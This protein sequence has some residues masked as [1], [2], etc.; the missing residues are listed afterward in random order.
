M[1]N[2]FELANDGFVFGRALLRNFRGKFGAFF[3]VVRLREPRFSAADDFYFSLDVEKGNVARVARLLVFDFEAFFVAVFD[4][5]FDIAL[6]RRISDAT[7][8]SSA[9]IRRSLKFGIFS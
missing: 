2:R 4:E 6:R 9:K 7:S 5:V 1:A 3:S 8:I